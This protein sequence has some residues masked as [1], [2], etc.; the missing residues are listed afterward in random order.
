[1]TLFMVFLNMCGVSMNHYSR[2]HRLWGL[3]KMFSSQTS[4]PRTTCTILPFRWARWDADCFL[5]C[6]SRVEAYMFLRLY[7][8]IEEF[9]GFARTQKSRKNSLSTNI[10]EFTVVIYDWCRGIVMWQSKQPNILSAMG[11]GLLGRA[12]KSHDEKIKLHA[13][14]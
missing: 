10:F 7:N 2:S 3:R 5:G 11:S 1:M 13:A 12:C 9:P 6:Y 8:N 14:W 4:T